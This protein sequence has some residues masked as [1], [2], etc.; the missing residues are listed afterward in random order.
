[1]DLK[2]VSKSLNPVRKTGEIMGRLESQEKTS[3][4]ADRIVSG[5]DEIK[6]ILSIYTLGASIELGEERLPESYIEGY[7][8]GMEEKVPDMPY[9]EVD[10]SDTVYSIGD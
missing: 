5:E 2:D 6:H 3:A 10:D 7:R 9:T 1:M 8:A 4:D